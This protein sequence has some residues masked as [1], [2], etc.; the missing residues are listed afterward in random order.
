MMPFAWAGFRSSR[1]AILSMIGALVRDK[2]VVPN[3]NG[4]GFVIGYLF[5][6]D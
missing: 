4:N 5:I 3:N 2:G 1:F 6:L